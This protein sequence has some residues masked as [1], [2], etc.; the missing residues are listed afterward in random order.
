MAQPLEIAHVKHAKIERHKKRFVRIDHDGIGYLPSVAQP[1]V[2]RQH[3]E[4]AAISAVDVQPDL[5][6]LANLRDFQN[7]VDARGR[8]RS[9]GR[10][11]RHRLETCLPIMRDSL[12]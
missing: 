8:S 7:R 2:F 5:L 3:G 11:D 9:H 12:A 4:P 6:F 1:S 10:D